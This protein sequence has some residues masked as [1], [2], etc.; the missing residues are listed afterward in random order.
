MLDRLIIPMAEKVLAPLGSGLFRVGLTSERLLVVGFILGLGAAFSASTGFFMMALVL[1]L[2]N[3][4]FDG[5]ADASARAGGITGFGRYLD[6]ALN[7]IVFSAIALSFAFSQDSN[8]LISAILMFSMLAWGG[9]TLAYAG[10]ARGLRLQKDASGNF[11]LDLGAGLVGTTEITLGLI[12]LLLAPEFFPAIGILLSGLI[13][14]TTIFRV[15]KA[16][17]VFQE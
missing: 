1:F 4:V 10:V 5:L 6:I 9:S 11:L 8:G 3:R 15:F 12:L 7:F 14:L 16:R 13:L 2:L 17:L